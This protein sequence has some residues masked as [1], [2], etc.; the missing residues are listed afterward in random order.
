VIVVDTSA[1]IAGFRGEPSATREL[2]RLLDEDRA[3][4]TMP[5]RLEL[6][7]GARRG[8]ASRLRRVLGAVP[9][10]VPT[11]QTWRRIDAWLEKAARAGQ[12]FAVMDLLI[13][14]TAKEHDA[15]VWSLDSDFARMAKLRF[16][17]LHRPPK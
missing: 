8:E 10:Y 17:K 4:L 14:S 12:R 1:W 11:E 16:I 5:G 7:E 15:P 2:R 6:L 13:A 3:A 9:L